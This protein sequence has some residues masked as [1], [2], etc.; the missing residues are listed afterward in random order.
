MVW[1]LGRRHGKVYDEYCRASGHSSSKGTSRTDAKEARCVRWPGG[2][3]C[4]WEDRS[5]VVGK[6]AAIVE[7]L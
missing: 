5:L 6:V 1:A 2:G 4:K 7:S 3:S